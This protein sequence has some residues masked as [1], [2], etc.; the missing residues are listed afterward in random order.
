M[1]EQ[2]QKEFDEGDRIRR[3]R[4]A[5][6]NPQAA[7]KAIG[8][9]MMSESRNAF[10]AQK[11]GNVEWAPRSVPNRFAVLM[12]F[13]QGGTTKPPARRFQPRPALVNRGGAGGLQS[14]IAFRLVGNDTVEVGT[15]LPY[16]SVHQ[17]GGTTESVQITETIQEKL[18]KWLKGSGKKWESFFRKYT[19]PSWLGKKDEQTVPAR[20]FIGVNEQTREDIEEAIGIHIYEVGPGIVRAG[21]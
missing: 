20:P 17:F 14:T 9:L 5:L 13:S 11:F 15:N 4:Q 7:L 6:G 21:Q 10:R 3:I 19:L 2:L 8:A 16:A 12:D 1:V 18:K